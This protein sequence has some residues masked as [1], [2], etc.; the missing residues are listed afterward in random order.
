MYLYAYSII[1]K[2]R[3]RVRASGALGT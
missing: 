1:V 2:S 3:V